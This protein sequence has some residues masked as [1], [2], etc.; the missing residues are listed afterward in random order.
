MVL[1]K[2]ALLIGI[3]YRDVPDVN[4]RGC[5]DDIINVSEILISKMGYLPS[6][7]VMLRDD[8][9]QNFPT[10]QRICDELQ[11]LMTDS[12]NCSEIWVHY[13]GHGALIQDNVGGTAYD[14]VLVPV[15][16][17]RFGFITDNDLFLMFRQSKCPTMVLVDSCNSGNVCELQWTTEHIVA[18]VF[19]TRKNA[20]SSTLPNSNIIVI[21]SC[22]ENQTASESF[23]TVDNEFEGAFTDAF[24]HALLMYGYHA[25]IKTIYRETCIGLKTKGY[26]QKPLMCS[27]AADISWSFAPYA[28]PLTATCVIKS[29]FKLF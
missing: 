22:K 19:N 3:N 16:Y 23:D 26:S 15:D 5:I 8:D 4:L 7:I 13:S 6:N 2:K 11:R 21:S 17:P 24:L 1:P 20:H 18:N 9:P 25:P 10:K 27:S 29:R 12:R 14:S 28:P